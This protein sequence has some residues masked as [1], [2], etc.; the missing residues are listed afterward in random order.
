MVGPDIVGADGKAELLW[1]PAKDTATNETT[2]ADIPFLITQPP[3]KVF[4]FRF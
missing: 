3:G 4:L 2:I 1:Q